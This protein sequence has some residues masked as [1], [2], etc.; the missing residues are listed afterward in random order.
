MLEDSGH[1]EFMGQPA[2]PC[3]AEFHAVQPHCSGRFDA[4]EPQQRVW[5]EFRPGLEDQYV[6]ADGVGLRDVRRLH[7]ERKLD[8]GVGGRTVAVH[9]PAGRD[10]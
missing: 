4:V 9:G 3:C 2:A 5:K 10:R 6:V 1:V 8:V 7:G